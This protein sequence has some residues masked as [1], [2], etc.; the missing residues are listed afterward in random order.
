MYDPQVNIGFSTA[1]AR[2]FFIRLQGLTS[3]PLNLHDH[4]DDA[5][6]ATV[7]Q[8]LEVASACSSGGG[9]GFMNHTRLAP[10]GTGSVYKISTARLATVQEGG[11]IMM[12]IHRDTGVPQLPPLMFTGIFGVTFTL[13]D[14]PLVI[15]NVTRIG[16][17]T[18]RVRI[19]M[20]PSHKHDNYM[21]GSQRVARH[22]HG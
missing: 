10:R 8:R 2:K 13:A 20:C 3:I 11:G 17:C 4:I 19:M 21:D 1:D 9:G 6:R 22:S 16:L 14:L 18:L 15:E 5:E 7:I 12:C